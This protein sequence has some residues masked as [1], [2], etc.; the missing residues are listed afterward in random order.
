[1]SINR[2]IN[3][4]SLR[5]AVGAPKQDSDADFQRK[6]ALELRLKYNKRGIAPDWVFGNNGDNVALF[7]EQATKVQTDILEFD[8]L[9]QAIPAICEYLNDKGLPLELW[10]GGADEILNLPWADYEVNVSKNQDLTGKKSGVVRAMAGVAET[11]TLVV[12]SSDTKFVSLNFLPECHIV[13]L[14]KNDILGSYEDA[15]DKISLNTALPRTINYITGPSRT[16]DIA[17]TLE[18]G[19]HGPIYL[20]VVIY[21]K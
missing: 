10:C 8:E 12:E 11:G 2:D 19:A 9:S 20:L 3:L 16:G 7:K 6:H 4:L 21:E 15:W 17:Q 13:F 1:M 14:Q 5:R 18:L